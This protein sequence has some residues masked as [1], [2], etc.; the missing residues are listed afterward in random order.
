[1]TKKLALVLAATLAGCMSGSGSGS[2]TA[3]YA[4]TSDTPDLVTID[5][6]VQ[7]VAEADEPT[8]YTDNSF[9]LFRGNEWY[10]S[11]RYRG[12]WT[13]VDAPPERLQR[14]DQPLAYAH[15][16]HERGTRTTFNGPSDRVPRP[17]SRNGYPQMPEPRDDVPQRQD[18]SQ[19]P[20]PLPQPPSAN[21]LPPQQQPPVMPDEASNPDDDR[22][23][24]PN[25]DLDHLRMR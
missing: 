25:G 23:D 13:R 10:R 18:P 6:G 2:S 17:H 8:F 4:S 5:D 15:F 14:I 16:H 21:P 24:M 19:S 1:M 9:W 20:A 11:D 22:G 12:T 7:V 3:R